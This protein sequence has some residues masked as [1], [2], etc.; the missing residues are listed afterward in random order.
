MNCSSDD[1]VA[2]V[3]CVKQSKLNITHFKCESIVEHL[4]PIELGG[5]KA[6]AGSLEPLQTS[7]RFN[8]LICGDPISCIIE[9]SDQ[10]VESSKPDSNFYFQFL[11]FSPIPV[12]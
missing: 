11:I 2:H 5:N 6:K 4:I 9:D 8:C 10:S 7:P 12:L 3:R 1:R